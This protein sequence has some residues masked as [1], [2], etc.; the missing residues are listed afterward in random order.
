MR[1]AGAGSGASDRRTGACARY[2]AA[3]PLRI[4]R[5]ERFPVA[6]RSVR[7]DPV[8]LMFRYKFVLNETEDGR[9]V[10]AIANPSQL[11][12]STDSLL[13]GKRIVTKVPRQADL[14][15]SAEDRKSKRVRKTRARDHARRDSRGRTRE[16]RDHLHRQVDGDGGADMS[17]IIRLAT[18]R[19]LTACSGGQATFTSRRGTTRWHQVSH[20]RRAHQRHAAHRQKQ[21]STPSFRASSGERARHFRR[22]VPQDGRSA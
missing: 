19:F 12:I 8:H 3:L 1:E 17:P 21:H 13:L 2:C 22:R 9:L 16:R 15:H 20:R 11:M 4:H 10:I 7:E 14:R 5:S 18:L 6:P